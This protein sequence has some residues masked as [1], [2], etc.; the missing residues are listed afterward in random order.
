MG[1][2]HVFDVIQHYR[3]IW[4]EV[5]LYFRP[6]ALRNR[7]LNNEFIYAETLARDFEGIRIQAY[8]AMCKRRF[9]YIPS[10]GDRYFEHERLFGDLVF[11]TFSEAHAD[12][13]MRAIV[14]RQSCTRRPCFIY[15]S[16]G[17]RI[18]TDGAHPQDWAN[19]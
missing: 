18:E 19:R 10:P 12:V 16:C 5:D 15:A 2:L 7:L 9:A 13:R 1:S 17:A 14:L 3:Y 6:S 8:T 4:D 11:E